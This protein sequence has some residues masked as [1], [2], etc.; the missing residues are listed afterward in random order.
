MDTEEIRESIA[1]MFDVRVS[2]V[3][4]EATSQRHGYT[5]CEQSVEIYVSRYT[6]D[7]ERTWKI[8]KVGK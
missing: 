1:A 3:K 4:V 8:G 5:D 2:D 6:T 7:S